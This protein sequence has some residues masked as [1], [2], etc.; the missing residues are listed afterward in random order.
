MAPP[1]AWADAPA[2]NGPGS[3]IAIGIPVTPKESAR[4]EA[5]KPAQVSAPPAET[6]ATTPEVSNEPVTA[7]ATA[8]A[9]EPAAEVPREAASAQAEEEP[10]TMKLEVIIPD[11]V[12]PGDVF[13]VKFDGKMVQVDVPEG[14][15]PGS[16]I[17]ILL[18]VTP[19]GSKGEEAPATTVPAEDAVPDEPSNETAALIEIAEQVPEPHPAVVPLPEE[20]PAGGNPEEVEYTDHH[21]EVPIHKQVYSLL[22]ELQTR[23]ANIFDQIVQV[24]IQDGTQAGGVHVPIV[25]M[26]QNT[27]K[28]AQIQYEAF[29]VQSFLGAPEILPTVYSGDDTDQPPSTP[30]A[31]FVLG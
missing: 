14:C 1:D 24:P 9:E 26:V 7:P 23:I 8:Q 18:P 5:G 2:D 22:V 10:A 16:A 15:R 27:S 30:N 29:E 17:S 20:A 28:V 3:T 6:V 13:E 12:K 25:Q 11:G 31:W 21:I 19:K 4:Q